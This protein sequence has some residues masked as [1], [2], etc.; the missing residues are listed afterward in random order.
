MSLSLSFKFGANP[1][2]CCLVLILFLETRDETRDETRE[3]RRKTENI[4]NSVQLQ[5]Q[6]PTGTE[7]GKKRV[8]TMPSFAFVRHHRW[9]TRVKWFSI[10]SL[11]FMLI[12]TF[13]RVTHTRWYIW[14]FFTL[15]WFLDPTPT[16]AKCDTFIEGN[17]V[18]RHFK[19][20]G[21]RHSKTFWNFDHVVI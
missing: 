5:L 13:P 10:Y 15:R 16:R 17:K 18:K 11:I 6:L 3:T 21:E 7:L 19:M 8:K 2:S 9:S 14:Y 20:C 4:A 1:P 12:E